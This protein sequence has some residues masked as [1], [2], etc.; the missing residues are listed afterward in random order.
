[1]HDLVPEERPDDVAIIAARVPLLPEQLTG[2]W[3]AE[4]TSLAD[5]RHLLRRWLRARGA[6][7][8]ELYDITVACQE[9]CAN[10]IEHAYRP[11]RA[12]FAVEAS[13][14]DG[15]VRVVVSDSGRWRPPRGGSSRGR[16]LQLMEAMMEHVDI[17]HGE[18]GTL[19]VLER[20]L[21]RRA[22]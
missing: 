18:D 16:G 11:G 10:A 3:P 7:E 2:R 19:V 5:V 13:Y 6:R 1:V 14:R 9:A 22:A 21:G 20:T 8:D 12:A 17:R 4:R 15:R